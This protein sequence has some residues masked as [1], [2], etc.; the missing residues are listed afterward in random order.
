MSVRQRNYQ[1]FRIYRGTEAAGWLSRP[2]RSRTRP[3]RQAPR[4]ADEASD[5]QPADRR[6]QRVR[7]HRGSDPDL[8]ATLKR[9]LTRLRAEA[10]RNGSGE[11]EWLFPRADGTLMNKD[12]AAGVFRR[13]LKRAG[14]QH[15]RVYDLRHTFASLLLAESAPITYVSAQLGHSSPAT[16]MRFYAR[17]I[18]SQ[19]KRWVNALDRKPRANE[20][21]TRRSRWNQ[22]VEP[23]E[24]A[25]DER[26]KVLVVVG[27][28]G[29]ARTSDFLINRRGPVTSRPSAFLRSSA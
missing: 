22:K 21:R 6:N 5:R 15:Y 25:P 26:A 2:R 24:G 17:W 7:A 4:V 11:P 14:L 9:H 28:P 27:S 1:K 20:P 10:L 3:I 13:I 19:G 16:P 23:A 12:Y 8:T 18:P 29:W